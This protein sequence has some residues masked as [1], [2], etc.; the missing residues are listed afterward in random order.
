[1]SHYSTSPLLGHFEVLYHVFKCLRKDDIYRVDFDPFQPKIYESSFASVMTDWKGLYGYIEEGLPPGMPGPLHKNA[2]TLCFVDANHTGNVVTR[3]LHTTVLIYVIN[4]PIIWFSKKHNNVDISTFGYEFV[5]M[6]IARDLIVALGY[7]LIGFGAPLYGPSN[8]MCDK[9]G[10]INKT[11]LPQYI[12]GK[13]HNAVN[14]H[15]FHEA[16]AVVILRVG[17]EYIETNLAGL[18]TK[19]SSWKRFHNL[20]PFLITLVKVSTSHRSSRPLL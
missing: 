14:Y 3:R 8:A 16:Y 19:I 18:L 11:S 15:A 1:M 5:V 2:H 10:V 17:K 6:R 20:L 9:Q 13:K 4:V 12:L 7:K